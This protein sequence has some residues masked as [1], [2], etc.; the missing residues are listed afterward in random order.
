MSRERKRVVCLWMVLC[1]FCLLSSQ[2][3]SSSV[4]AAFDFNDSLNDF[5]PV[6]PMLFTFDVKRKEKNY[7][8]ICVICAFFFVFTY[9]IKFRECC[10]WFQ[11]FTQWCCSSF[12]KHVLYYGRL[13]EKSVLFMHFIYICFF[14]FHDPNRVQW[15]LYLI[16][17]LHSMMLLLYL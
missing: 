14:C 16:P 6:S 9:Q 4:S 10:V 7:L 5:A 11:C 12:F 1:V 8:L 15:V 2:L 3:R 17:M 13:K